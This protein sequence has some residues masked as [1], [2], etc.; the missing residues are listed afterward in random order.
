MKH[1]LLLICTAAA[2]YGAAAFPAH[3]EDGDSLPPGTTISTS[4]P[5]FVPDAKDE[6]SLGDWCEDALAHADTR[7]SA[8]SAAHW[9]MSAAWVLG[10]T[11]G[12]KKRAATLMEGAASQFPPGDAAAGVAWL[13]AA[14]LYRSVEDLDAADR[15][16][17]SARTYQDARAPVDAPE[18]VLRLWKAMHQRLAR[19]V[20]RE[21]VALAEARGEY[22]EAAA[23]LEAA[24]ERRERAGY[25]ADETAEVWAR[26]ARFHA[27]A[28]AP[29]R[30]LAAVDRAL[31]LVRDEKHRA[32]WTMWRLYCKHGCLD[33]EG[34]RRSS[35]RG[36]A[37]PSSRTPTLRCAPS[38]GIR[39]P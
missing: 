6:A 14:R 26:A 21:A 10:S 29:D 30:A 34:P 38:T 16:L 1:A 3:A 19:Y 13:E 7:R 25:R 37:R 32:Q 36:L 22:G 39:T 11:L 15:A 2:L 23:E 18:S 20:P 4:F 27:R 12:K 24:A 9:R 31:D 8:P 5:R 35:R 33:D 28:K 17:A